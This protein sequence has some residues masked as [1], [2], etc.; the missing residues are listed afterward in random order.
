MSE[1]GQ[2]LKFLHQDYKGRWLT[3]DVL[4]GIGLV[5]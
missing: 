2:S 4:E 1:E 3:E 5:G